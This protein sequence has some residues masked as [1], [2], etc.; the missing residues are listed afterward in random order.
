MPLKKPSKQK[1]EAA[2][3]ACAGRANI[4]ELSKSGMSKLN[5]KFAQEGNPSPEPQAQAPAPIFVDSDS[6]WKSGYQGGVNYYVLS[7]EETDTDDDGEA[8][9]ESFDEDEE[10]IITILKDKAHLYTQIQQMK[11][12]WDWKIAEANRSFGYNG[13][14]LR[15]V[16]RQWQEAQKRQAFR[17]EAKT[18]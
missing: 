13:H 5:P 12:A 2:A 7:E 6:E 16:W 18:S 10:D 4:Q 11:S 3:R 14:L 8:G 15:T 9:C 1:K 17:E